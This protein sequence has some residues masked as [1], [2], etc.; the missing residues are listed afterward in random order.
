MTRL[1]RRSP[2]ADHPLLRAAQETRA[3]AG[4]TVAVGYPLAQ[5]DGV[6]TVVDLGHARAALR[7][8][9][10]AGRRTLASHCGLDLDPSAF[11]VGR[12]T[13]TRFGH[14]GMTLSR[15]DDTTFELLVFRGYAAYAFESLVESA[16]EFGV[17]VGR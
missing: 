4:V 5:L 13:N 16:T 3:Q 1:E 6:A 15:T 12:A 9:G 10:P 14:L 11:P 2:L 7:L 8:T 17:H